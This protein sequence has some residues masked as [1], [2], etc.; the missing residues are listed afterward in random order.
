MFV[1][2][3]GPSKAGEPHGA[4]PAPEGPTLQGCDN[5]GRVSAEAKVE[6]GLTVYTFK[7]LELKK[8]SGTVAGTYRLVFECPGL[9]S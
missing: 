7:Q 2:I 6:G 8:D 4:T 9:K 1:A 5:V 3:S